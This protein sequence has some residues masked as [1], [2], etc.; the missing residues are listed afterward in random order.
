MKACALSLVLV[1]TVA[2]ACPATVL[3]QVASDRDTA[4][5]SAYELSVAGLAKY[6]Q[7]NTNLAQLGEALSENCDEDE[8]DQSIDG[9]VAQM[10]GVPGAAE[11]IESAGLPLREYVVFTWAM[12][13]AG[14]GAWAL[15]QPGGQL[16]PGV[17]KANAEFARDHGAEFQEAASLVEPYDCDDSEDEGYADEVEEESDYEE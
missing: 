14:I 12:V 6:R 3:A 13:G 2:S 9:M 16:P 10:R 7:A 4:E 1:L 17:S 11:A 15:D 8:D 5:I